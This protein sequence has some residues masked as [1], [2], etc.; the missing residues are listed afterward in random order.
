MLNLLKFH[1][2]IIQPNIDGALIGGVSLIAE[3]FKVL[4]KAAVK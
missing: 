2:L 1:K 4:V 3:D